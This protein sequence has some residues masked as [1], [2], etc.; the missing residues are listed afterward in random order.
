[1]SDVSINYKGMEIASM[2]DSGTKTLLTSGKYCEDD[3][4]VVYTKPSGGG[5]TLDDYVNGTCSDDYVN[6]DITYLADYLF[7]RYPGVAYGITYGGLKRF[8]LKNVTRIGVQAFYLMSQ[9]QTIFAP[10]AAISSSCFYGA[11]NLKTAVVSGFAGTITTNGQCFMKYASPHLLKTVDF[12]YKKNGICGQMFRNA[13]LFDTLILREPAIF[14]LGNV[15]AFDG[16]PFASG[17]SGGT[18]YVPKALYDHLGDGSAL[19][20][21]AATNWSTVNGYGTI[22]WAQIEGSQYETAYA[23]G[24]PIT[25]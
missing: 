2:D 9:L 21:K 22:T 12:V 13:D 1:M 15:N 4:D 24:T 16:T 3:I 8:R 6:D 25:A 11:K 19:D 10:L 23:D 17:G 14:P 7:F 5:D 18:I 20:Y